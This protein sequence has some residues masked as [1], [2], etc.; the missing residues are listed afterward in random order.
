MK[1]YLQILGTDTI[2]SVPS[3][4]LIFEKQRYLFNC[5]E[6]T[7]RFC[8]EHKAKFSKMN[9]IFFTKLGWDY[10]GGIPGNI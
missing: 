8:A 6:G 5:G 3:F 7:Q 10:I 1:I 9:T 4:T 2:D